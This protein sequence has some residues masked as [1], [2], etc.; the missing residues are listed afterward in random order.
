MIICATAMSVASIPTDHGCVKNTF[1]DA[2][3]NRR[4]KSELKTAVIHN[5]DFSIEVLLYDDLDRVVR[6]I[7]IFPDGKIAFRDFGDPKKDQEWVVL[8]PVERTHLA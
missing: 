2:I 3:S 8:A 5:A 6:K 1:A 7:W 4:R